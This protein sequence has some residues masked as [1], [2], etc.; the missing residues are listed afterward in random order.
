MSCNELNKQR[1]GRCVG[2]RAM[3]RVQHLHALRMTVRVQLFTELRYK[4]VL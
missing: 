1:Q 4:A 3:T 2:P